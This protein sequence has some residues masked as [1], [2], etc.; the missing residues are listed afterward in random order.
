FYL[1]DEHTFERKIKEMFISLKIDQ[2]ESKDQVLANY[3]NTIYLGRGNYGVETAAQ[4]YFDEP[5][6][7]LN[8]AQSAM[9]AAM[10][11]R[12]GAA[13]PAKDPGEYKPRFNY[14]LDNMVEEGYLTKAERQ[15]VKFPKVQKDHKSKSAYSGTKGYLLEYVR[16]EL[17]HDADIS[18]EQLKRGGYRIVTTFHQK[19]MKAAK[20]A[21]DT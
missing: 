19:A 1:N 3:L 16:K 11:Q 4:E 6:S 8:V 2:Q 21:V 12:P 15:Q 7:K 17:N 14:V 20:D 10:I 5:A 9:L 13:D 18:P